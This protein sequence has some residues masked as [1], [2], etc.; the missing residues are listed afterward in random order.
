MKKSF[1]DF[2][3]IYTLAIFLLGLINIA[4]ALIG[5]LCYLGPLVLYLM[6]RDKTWC[7][8]Y[9]PRASFLN[10]SLSKISLHLKAPKWLN[11][12]SVKEFFI[13]YMGLNLFFASMS[14]LMVALGRIQ[15]MLYVRLFMVFK[16]PLV[17]PQIVNFDWPTAVLHFSYRIYSM[18]LSSIMIGLVLGFLYAPRTW[19]VICPVNTLSIPKRL[20]V[21]HG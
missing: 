21:K 17:L 4:F 3:F 10:T 1:Q 8:T 20:K 7:R 13:I 16:A 19:C 9:C 11:S 6:H 12:A 5:A 15:P 18:M 2:S 14:T